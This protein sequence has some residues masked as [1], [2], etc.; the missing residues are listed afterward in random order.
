MKSSIFTSTPCFSNTSTMSGELRNTAKC[1]NDF[2]C[3][4]SVCSFSVQM[5]VQMVLIQ[6]VDLLAHSSPS[7]M[8]FG[9]DGALP[10]LLI[11]M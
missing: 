8:T 5:C 4:Q 7:D 6:S 1:S 10:T 3:I 2:P 11:N 9:L